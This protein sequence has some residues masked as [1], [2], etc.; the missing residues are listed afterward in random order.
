[1]V[2]G[3]GGVGASDA[4]TCVLVSGGDGGVSVGLVGEGKG[5][6]GWTG[7]EQG[8]TM[9]QLVQQMRRGDGG[10]DVHQGGEQ[11]GVSGSVGKT[12][13]S[14]C[15]CSCSCSRC[16]R[17]CCVLSGARLLLYTRVVVAQCC[18]RIGGLG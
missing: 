17:A 13:S 4:S 14:C 7:G 15:S 11:G 12:S 3:V 16:G 5:A 10:G 18:M 1:M 2:V 6:L 8:E 9:L